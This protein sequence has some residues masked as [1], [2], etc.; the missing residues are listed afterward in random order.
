MVLNVYLVF[1]EGGADRTLR[2][3]YVSNGHRV[4]QREKLRQEVEVKVRGKGCPPVVETWEQ[5]G[6]SE[7]VLAV[8]RR[9]KFEVR[10]L[11]ES[12]YLC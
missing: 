3:G 8:I 10:L 9:N 6:F 5:C 4:E 12:L 2:R 11:S 1:V 7:R